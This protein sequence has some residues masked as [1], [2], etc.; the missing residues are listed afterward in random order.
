M[1]MEEEKE[2]NFGEE[3]EADLTRRIMR[4]AFGDSSSESDHD[5]CS[6]PIGE[7]F[8][9]LSCEES[10]FE[11]PT[12]EPVNDIQGLWFCS[13]FLSSEDQSSLLSAIY[14]DGWLTDQHNQ[15]MRFGDL[16]KWALELSRRV[17][18]AVCTGDIR[19]GSEL[20][21]STGSVQNDPLPFDLLWREPLFDQLIANVYKPGEGICSHVDLMRFE[22]GIAIISLESACVMQF[23][24]EKENE[25]GKE[26]EVPVFL[27]PGSLVLMHGEA[28]YS[29][30]HGI[31][32]GPGCQIWDGKEIKQK[33]RTSVTLRKL[34]PAPSC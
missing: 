4:E 14:Q 13:N 33:R 11:V 22:D 2:E 16:P 1:K 9:L 15:A 30:K 7:S 25:N 27:N 3:Q 20:N 31:N 12:W 29:W 8:S 6:S 34:C 19:A 18:S 17:R 5:E 21:L 32:R 24:L 28:R 10:E 23:S 26:K